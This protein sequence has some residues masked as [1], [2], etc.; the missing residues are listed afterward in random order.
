[1]TRA[2]ETPGESTLAGLDPANALTFLDHAL[3]EP[4]AADEIRIITVPAAG[5]PLALL[6]GTGPSVFWAAPDGSTMAGVGASHTITARGAR[7]FTEIRERAAELWARVRTISHPTAPGPDPDSPG[8]GSADVWA[9]PRLFG[10]FSFLPGAHAGPWRPFGDAT[11]VLPRLLL[12]DD[13]AGARLSIAVSDP[14]TDGRRAELLDDVQRALDRLRADRPDAGAP[15]QAAEDGSGLARGARA[16]DSPRDGEPGG[17]RT[18]AGPV[19]PDPASWIDAVHSIREW[20]HEGR[21]EKVVTARREVIRVEPGVTARAVLRRLAREPTA[22]RFAFRHGH[23]TF[24]GATPERLVRSHARE[25]RTEALAGTV[26]AGEEARLAPL[27]ESVKEGAE[28]AFVVRAIA[29]ALEPVCES[30]HYPATPEV[31]RLRHVHHLRTPFRGRLAREV[32]VLELVE[33]LHP[34]PAVG[35]WPTEVALRWIREHEREDR[36]WYAAP[37]GWLDGRG[38]GEF[39]VALRSALLHH[40]RAYVYAGAGIVADSD[41]ETELQETEVKLRTMKEALVP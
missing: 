9:V 13:D 11:F 8:A 17:R 7:R 39:A 5:E 38:D 3:R 29:E 41:A 36:G 34:T 26:A 24:V 4:F 2:R 22:F 33:R 20:I 1:M 28:H 27:L 32:H 30:L 31:Q 16:V 25:I 23:G 6:D 40:D 10:G 19:S 21:A 37:V 35:G 14:G 12:T 18:I 15:I